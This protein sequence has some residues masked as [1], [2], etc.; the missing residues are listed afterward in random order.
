MHFHSTSKDDYAC[1][2]FLLLT[3]SKFSISRNFSKLSYLMLKWAAVFYVKEDKTPLRNGPRNL[4]RKR[5]SKKNDESGN[6]ISGGF[7]R[8]LYFDDSSR[9]FGPEDAVN[10]STLKFLI[11]I[12]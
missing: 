12:L 10:L 2:V 8:A 3:T 4:V 7:A 11:P 9:D 1:L 6:G 5:R